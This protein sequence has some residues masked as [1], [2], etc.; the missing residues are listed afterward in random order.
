M[1]TPKK[2]QAR[3]LT[4]A[5]QSARFIET[6]RKLGADERPEVFEKLLK[7][8]APL[9]DHKKRSS[10]AM[11]PSEEEVCFYFE[12]GAAF[13]QW[14]LL[15]RH[16]LEVLF[17]SGTEEQYS[18][19]GH[20]FFSIEGFRSRMAFA[21]AVL[22]KRI[23]D[24]KH[25]D[26]WSALAKKLAAASV[27]RN[28]LAHRRVVAYPDGPPG[29]RHALVQWIL[30]DDDKPRKRKLAPQGSFCVRDI[31]RIR[32]EFDALSFALANLSCRLHNQPEPFPTAREQPMPPPPIRVIR[33]RMQKALLGHAKPSA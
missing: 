21:N 12:M 31:V 20:G 30:K 13:A 32:Y 23:T 4:A 29:R 22:Q 27:D 3:R 15:E 7:K 28:R 16:I 2:K 9:R 24:R 19:L 11:T 8:V 6:A 18:M 26:D 25:L 14:A 10:Q 33:D 1:K 17:F 5:E